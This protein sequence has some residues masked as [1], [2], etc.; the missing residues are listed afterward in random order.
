MA[1]VKAVAESCANRW[2][3]L[4]IKTWNVV[5]TTFAKRALEVIQ[6]RPLPDAV[7]F[8]TAVRIRAA[9]PPVLHVDMIP[10]A[11]DQII[12]VIHMASIARFCIHK[13]KERE[14]R[15]ESESVNAGGW[16]DVKQ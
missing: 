3:I 13:K 1:I 7:R 6:D 12:I 5:A 10:I 11:V 9:T 2:T 8:A 16:N 4:V 15:T 14:R